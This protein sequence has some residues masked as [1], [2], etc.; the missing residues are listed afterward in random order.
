MT[1]T[2]SQTESQPV[3]RIHPPGHRALLAFLFAATLCTAWSSRR[4]R[5][6]RIIPRR[7]KPP[8]P[9]R[10]PTCTGPLRE[11]PALLRHRI[12]RRQ[13]NFCPRLPPAERAQLSTSRARGPT[14]LF[15]SP[16]SR[17]RPQGVVAPDGHW[18]ASD[19]RPGR[20]LGRCGYN[21]CAGVDLFNSSHRGV[22]LSYR[23]IR[24]VPA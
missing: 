8:I 19:A 3:V 4:P 23:Q 20:S 16:A 21:H 11:R 18:C 12:A 15:L 14:S 2:T 5:N 7:A 13:E 22:P 10:S 1:A 9:R 24:S 17:H 6:W